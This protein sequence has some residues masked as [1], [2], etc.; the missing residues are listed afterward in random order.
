ME[1]PLF[2][3]ICLLPGGG[4]LPSVQ[5]WAAGRSRNCVK[6]EGEGKAIVSWVIGLWD[7]GLKVTI[8]F[9]TPK[10]EHQEIFEGRFRSPANVSTLSSL[11][12]VG[13]ASSP[14][15]GSDAMGVWIGALL[16]S[17]F[18]LLS[19]LPA[20]PQERRSRSILVLDQSQST[21]VFFLQVFSGLRAAIDADASAHTTLFL[22]KSRPQ[23]L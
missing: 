17:V 7:N 11:A 10:V 14:N 15:V 2:E 5:E 20:T 23:P 3:T 16:I 4:P 6:P 19:S 18:V 9:E 22:R 8:Q 1:S 12:M 13:Q 21:G